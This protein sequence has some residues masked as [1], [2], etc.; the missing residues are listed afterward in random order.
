M[1]PTL[2]S[3]KP[4]F[5][6]DTDSRISHIPPE[7]SSRLHETPVSKQ[8]PSPI[9]HRPLYCDHLRPNSSSL[10]NNPAAVSA[11]E[12]DHNGR[13]TEVDLSTGITRGQHVN[14]G[15]DDQSMLPKAGSKSDATTLLQ[16]VT[17]KIT[18]M[19]VAFDRIPQHGF[20]SS[21]KLHPDYSS[22]S[23]AAPLYPSTSQ[24]H[25]KDVAG[26]ETGTDE[27]SQ[28]E[29]TSNRHSGTEPS[30]VAGRISGTTRHSL[31]EVPTHDFQTLSRTLAE[32]T[33]SQPSS[34]MTG[35]T[36][37]TKTS[38]RE[39]QDTAISGSRISVGF[40]K[41]GVVMLL[42]SVLGGILALI[43]ILV[44]HRFILLHFNRHAGGS[45]IVRS[46]PAADIPGKKERTLPR[47]AEFSHFSIDT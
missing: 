10:V 30:V 35:P 32:T 24:E 22:K 40:S 43:G 7:D 19:P 47:T 41:Q 6:Q 36:S 25:T 1:Q 3:Q 5:N 2:A 38:N 39:W 14:T 21:D 33:S 15:F 46:Q 42:S 44:I 23:Y 8:F 11:T 34:Q 28:K 13:A 12:V 16:E 4:T 26:T 29:T 45:V 17:S 31:S 18:L 27:F 20:A 37:A 9:L